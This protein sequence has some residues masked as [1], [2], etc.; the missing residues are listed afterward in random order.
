M[1]HGRFMVLE[2]AVYLCISH[3]FMQCDYYTVAAVYRNI[4]N[5]H[6]IYCL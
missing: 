4:D 2:S 3:I 5:I 1:L 6:V